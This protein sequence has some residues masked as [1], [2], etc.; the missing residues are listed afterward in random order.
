MYLI[1]AVIP[2]HNSGNLSHYWHLFVFAL[3]S[4]TCKAAILS[5]PCYFK[6]RRKS[7]FF[8]CNCTNIK[9]FFFNKNI[10]FICHK[11]MIIDVCVCD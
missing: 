11:N 10:L 9:A 3:S 1:S 5:Y 4:E 8:I 7:Y 2:R 6:A